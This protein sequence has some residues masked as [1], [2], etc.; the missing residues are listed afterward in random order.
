MAG[1]VQKVICVRGDTEWQHRQGMVRR[2]DGRRLP[3]SSH[4]GPWVDERVGS[5]IKSQRAPTRIYEGMAVVYF[6]F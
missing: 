6:S 5:Q 1:T 2:R 4:G 3:K